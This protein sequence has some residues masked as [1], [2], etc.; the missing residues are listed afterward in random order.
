MKNKPILKSSESSLEEILFGF[1]RKLLESS[2]KEAEGLKC[3][4]SQIDTLAYIA[5]KGNP[6]MKDIATHLGITPPSATA[7]VEMMQKKKFITRVASNNDRRTIQITLT[8]K[9]WKFFKSL[10]ERK[11]AIFAKMLSKLKASE[12]KEFIRI[13]T[14]LITE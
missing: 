7:I 12:R 13:L 9:A 3:P 4:I 1:R 2:R 14:K 10:H 6:S 8:P 5:E 11:F